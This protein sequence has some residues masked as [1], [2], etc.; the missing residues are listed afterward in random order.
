MDKVKKFSELKIIRKNDRRYDFY[1][2]EEDFLFRMK[3]EVEHFLEARRTVG[4]FDSYDGTKIAYYS[5]VPEK[6]KACIVISHGFCEFNE[7]YN[8]MIYYFLKADYSVYFIEHRG[9]G[10]SGRK[11]DN[12]SKVHVS[13]YREYT[14]DLSIFM[15]RIVIPKTNGMKR[16]I[17]GHSMGGCIAALFIEKYPEMFTKAVLSSPM[18]EVKYGKYPSAFA[19][20]VIRFYNFRGRGDEYAFGEHDFDGVNVFEYSSCKSRPRYEYI[21]GKRINN[22]EYQTYGGTFSWINAGSVAVRKVRRRSSS[23]K[24]K[25]PVLLFQAG[26][27]RLVK[28]HGQNEFARR[29][30]DV[31]L[32]RVKQS[33]HEIFNALETVRV[34]Y[35][36]KIFHFLE[37]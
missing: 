27:D 17:F 3:S 7:K 21:F 35:Y 29:A 19:A 28:G 16:F 2:G 4:S 31:E 30:G 37:A 5:Y 18:M 22:P 34:S 9:H 10:H 1:L 25:I 6:P 26:H 23:G 14:R 36:E 33:R 20:P 12:L 11:L 15:N 24:V 13:S 32:V 8:E